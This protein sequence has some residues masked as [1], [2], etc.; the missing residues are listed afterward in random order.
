MLVI[1]A[2]LLVIGSVLTAAAQDAGMFIAGHM[3]QGLCTTC[4]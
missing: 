4:S 3:I 2:V 1:Y